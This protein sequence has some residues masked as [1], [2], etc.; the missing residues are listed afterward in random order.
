M[1]RLVPIFL[2][3]GCF[4]FPGASIA[5]QRPFATDA[6]AE[7]ATYGLATDAA[8][9]NTLALPGVDVGTPSWGFPM[10]AAEE[11]R[12]DLNGRIHF[13]DSASRLLMPYVVALP[14]YAGAY[15][16]QAGDGSL[17]VLLTKP[18]PAIAAEI[19]RRAP[20]DNRSVRILFGSQR[21]WSELEDAHTRLREAWTLV[22]PGIQ[23]INAGIDTIGNAVRVGV[24]PAD[25][26]LAS[27]RAKLVA[28]ELGVPITVEAALPSIDTTCT[29]RDHCYSP[30]R[31]GIVIRNNTD[32]SGGTCTMAFHIVVG[33]D[34]QFMTA[35]HCGCAYSA[36]DW[37]HMGF[38]TIGNEAGTMTNLA[39]PKDMMKVQMADSQAS[40]L[41]YA[42]SGDMGDGANPIEGETVFASLGISDAKKSGTV[43][44][45]SESW[46]STYCKKTVYGADSSISTIP[47]DSGSPIYRRFS[48]GGEWYITPIGIGDT[49]VGQFGKVRAALDYWGASVVHP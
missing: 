12:L 6:L 30:M 41:M 27:Q 39:T 47:G 33:T 13:A 42:D 18:D 19:S 24:A 4:A 43:T 36:V 11:A 32:T 25:V 34:E 37:H 8:T 14:T 40:P 9:L 49:A 15:V 2:I 20:A 16:D 1:R 26:S 22:A 7:R 45:V 44:D 28:L 5:A 46:T 23:V 38:G 3:V 17:V 48:Y 29:D 35:G 31:P 21:T 10:T